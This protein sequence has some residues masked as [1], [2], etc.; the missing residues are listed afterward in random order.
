M[1][2]APS[3]G[4][5]G[6]VKKK[7]NKVETRVRNFRLFLYIFL[8]FLLILSFHGDGFESPRNELD[9]KKNIFSLDLW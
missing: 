1:T 2:R 4:Q 7:N 6:G 3:V 8:L 5:S 9:Q